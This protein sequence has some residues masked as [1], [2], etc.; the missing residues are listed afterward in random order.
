[1]HS[2]T[3]HSPEACKGSKS[4]NRTIHAHKIPKLV[5]AS[6]KVLHSKTEVCMYTNS[7]FPKFLL[8]AASALVLNPGPQT[9]NPKPTPQD[10]EPQTQN[11][12]P[13]KG[14]NS[15]MQKPP[16]VVIP[17]LVK[18]SI[19]VLHSKTEVCMYTNS[20]FPKLLLFAASA[21]ILNPQPQTQTPKPKTPK[22]VKDP[23]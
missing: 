19:Q 8:F 17:K 10:P 21:V 11:P 16:K 3:F 7:I 5:K 18:A 9:L 20:I 13:C 15:V 14:S 2:K 23:I 1:M 4:P 6:I 12:K 22:L